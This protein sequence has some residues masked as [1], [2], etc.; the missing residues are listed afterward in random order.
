MLLSE[1]ELGLS[2]EHAGIVELP[3]DAPVGEPYAAW[4]KLDDPV[5]DIAVTTNRPDCLGVSGIARD[6]AA[7]GAG[8]LIDR[9]VEPVPGGFPCPVKVTLGFGATPSLCRAFALRLVRGVRNGPSPDWLHRRL[10][11][12]GLRPI[13]ALVDITNYLTFDAAVRSVFDAARWSAISWCGAATGRSSLSTDAA[14]R[15]TTS[16][17]AD[18]NGVGRSPEYR[19]RGDRLPKATDV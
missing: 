7:A 6:L 19:R 4:A 8:R 14:I 18:K 11:E 2:D 1:R 17:I 15:S 9:P 12:I 5:L 16:V 13:N 10:H 3:D